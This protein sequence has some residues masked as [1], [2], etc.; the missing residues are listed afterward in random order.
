ME[1]IKDTMT[2]GRRYLLDD[3]PD[4]P[5]SV[6]THQLVTDGHLVTSRY[7]NGSAGPHQSRYNADGHLVEGGSFFRGY[8]NDSVR[9]HR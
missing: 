6:E 2:S 9:P 3:V 1:R 7:R 5:G 4:V 8:S